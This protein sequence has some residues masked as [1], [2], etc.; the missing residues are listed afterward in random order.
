MFF[1]S[2]TTFLSFYILAT[3]IKRAV[4]YLAG[5]T[6]VILLKDIISFVRDHFSKGTNTDSSRV[7]LNVRF[8]EREISITRK[9]RK[10]IITSSVL[11]GHLFTIMKTI[12][13][14]HQEYN[15]LYAGFDPS[16]RTSL[17]NDFI[18]S[19]FIG[20]AAHVQGFFFGGALTAICQFMI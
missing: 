12:H 13:Y 8:D 10:K 17:P 15:K 18:E 1:N 19:F 14:F 20:H 4:S 7:N 16:F 9:R 5:A 2:F 3:F 11:F 6:T